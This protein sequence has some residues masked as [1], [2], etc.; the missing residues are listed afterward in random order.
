MDNY[1]IWDLPIFNK[2]FVVITAL[3]H[4]GAI[5]MTLQGLY[6]VLNNVPLYV[7][8]TCI[9]FV[10]SPAFGGS[11]CIL[12]QLES[13]FRM[14]AGWRPLDEDFSKH[15]ILWMVNKLKGIR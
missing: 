10:T 6:W 2:T 1:R 13:Y 15:Y 11:L 5:L 8:I 3:V 12:N 14:K 9:F 7:G 4:L